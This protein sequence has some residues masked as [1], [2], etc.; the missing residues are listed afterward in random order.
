M[1]CAGLPVP[2]SGN[3]FRAAARGWSSDR[4]WR[5]KCWQ[6]GQKMPGSPTQCASSPWESVSTTQ[7]T[8]GSG[9]PFPL[10]QSGFE[11]GSPL[12][13]RRLEA[14]VGCQAE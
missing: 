14:N 6:G 7:P 8:D 10:E 3:T 4:G 11:E 12:E 13:L 2:P 9:S 1:V 5:L